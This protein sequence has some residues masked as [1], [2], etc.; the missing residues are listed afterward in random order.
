MTS[1]LTVV[2]AVSIAYC[3]IVVSITSIGLY[4]LGI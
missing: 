3:T 4:F 2:L 1:I